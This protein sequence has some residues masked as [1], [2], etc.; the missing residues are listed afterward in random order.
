MKDPAMLFYTSD[1]LT[2]VALLSM[3]ERGQYI[4]LLCLQQQHGHMT[5]QE[6]KAAVGKVS[7]KV[8]EK[9]Q[10]DAEGKFFNRRAELEIQKR[11]K[12]AAAQ[13]ENVMKRWAREKEEKP[14]END[15]HGINGGITMVNT[16]VIPLENENE[17]LNIIPGNQDGEILTARAR[18]ETGTFSE[19]NDPQLAQFM[20]ALMDQLG[21]ISSTAAQE[22]LAWYKDVG[23]DLCLHAVELALDNGKRSWS[24][25]RAI[26]GRWEKEGI[27]TL[28]AAQAEEKAREKG[29]KA[30]GNGGGRAGREKPAFGVKP[31]NAAANP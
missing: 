18:V 15:H 11:E 9:F 23:G 24:Y 2:G 5:A 14:P 22:A 16:M 4:T 21:P 29:G 31:R 3:A 1:F 20:A 12:H 13:R 30:I 25:V 27:K 10:R 26:L 8:M 19:K 17:N 6:M 7:A 28:A